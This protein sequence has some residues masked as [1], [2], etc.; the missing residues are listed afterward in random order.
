MSDSN[1]FDIKSAHVRHHVCKGRILA[2]I[3]NQVC[4]WLS[5]LVGRI[6]ERLSFQSTKSSVN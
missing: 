4:Q 2:E 5:I 6:L 1:M 3:A